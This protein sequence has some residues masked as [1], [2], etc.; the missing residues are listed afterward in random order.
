MISQVLFY[1][2]LQLISTPAEARLCE[3]IKGVLRSIAPS[4]V[5][6]T[7]PEGKTVLID[8]SQEETFNFEKLRNMVGKSITVCIAHS[9]YK[10][11]K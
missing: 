5:V 1:A 4:S 6:M 11:Q 7:T 9:H 10:I 2:I 8:P 3:E